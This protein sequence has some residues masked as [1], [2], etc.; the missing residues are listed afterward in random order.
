[1]AAVFFA[2]LVP[3]FCCRPLDKFCYSNRPTHRPTPKQV[4]SERHRARLLCGG[5]TNGLAVF[6]EGPGHTAGSLINREFATP[7]NYGGAERHFDL[8]C[9][10]E[11]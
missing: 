5:L 10:S 3:C 1:M 11:G 4:D 9:D 6:L 2:S 8:K 7:M